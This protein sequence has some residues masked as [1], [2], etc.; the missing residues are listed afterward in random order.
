MIT[1]DP[2]ARRGGLAG[3]VG[4]VLALPMDE[5]RRARAAAA[6]AAAVAVSG[7]EEPRYGYEV[8]CDECGRTRIF[9]AWTTKQMAEVNHLGCPFCGARWDLPAPVREPPPRQPRVGPARI[10]VLVACSDEKAKTRGR[11]PAAALYKSPLF[12]RSLAYA[13]SL[14][15]DSDIRIL[16]ALHGAVRLDHRLAPYDWRLQQMSKRE[17]ERWGAMV[18]MHLVDDFGLGPVEATVLAG[19]LYVDALYYGL[20]EDNRD[21]WKLVLPFG[22]AAGERLSVG[23]RLRWLNEHTRT[24]DAGLSIWLNHA[25]SAA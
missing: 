18:T 21:G 8:T 15:V 14:V 9:N 4:R 17:R 7:P 25:R 1:P 2:N 5:G 11:L 19:A 22:E 10:V 24:S 6:L 3:A 13:R 23:R 20:W 16:S 12:R